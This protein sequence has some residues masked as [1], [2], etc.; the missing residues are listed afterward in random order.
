MKEWRKL[1]LVSTNAKKVKLRI[2]KLNFFDFFFEIQQSL[3]HTF[4][5]LVELKETARI[6]RDIGVNR[7]KTIADVKV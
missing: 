2:N 3:L 6:A 1:P 7:N 4:Q 5:S